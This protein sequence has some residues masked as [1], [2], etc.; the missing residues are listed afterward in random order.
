M[1]RKVIS[2]LGAPSREIDKQDNKVTDQED[3][4]QILGVE[5]EAIPQK[6]K[7]AYR[8]L[9]FQYHPDNNRG[10]PAALEKMKKVNEAYAV[11]SDPRKKESY[12][13]L[14]QEYGPFAYDRFRRTILT[15]IFSKARTSTRSSRR[16]PGPSGLEVL[17]RSSKNRTVT[18]IE[19]SN[20]EDRASSREDL[21]SMDRDIGGLQDRLPARMRRRCTGPVQGS[22]GN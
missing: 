21:S 16:W 5:R 8:K 1:R 2:I 4:Y 19:P 10:N 12:D 13:A 22:Q 3:Y 14:S 6:I 9:A 20:L 7:E 18:D 11:L 15:R 17:R